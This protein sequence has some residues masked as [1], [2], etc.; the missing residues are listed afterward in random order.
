MPKPAVAALDAH[1]GELVRRRHRQAA[2]PDGLDQLED[3]G[4]GAD[5]ERQREE[6]RQR[7]RPVLAQGADGVA[8]I[9][10][11]HL[12][13]FLR[14]L[15]ERGPTG[16]RSRPAAR[17]PRSSTRRDA[18]RRRRAPSRGRTRRGTRPDRARA[19]RGRRARRQGAPAAAAGGPASASPRQEPGGAGVGEQL[20]EA[21]RLGL[22]D[23]APE[24]RELVVAA[25]L[26]VVAPDRA[27]RRA[28]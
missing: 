14:G 6:H 15:R 1:L 17:S 23:A 7:E 19:A 24:R 18:D 4:V 12:R 5:A 16:P 27:A 25:P 9:L 21:A 13:V 8:E 20:L 11:Q 22:G 3:G 2:Q 28:R 26:V 10:Q